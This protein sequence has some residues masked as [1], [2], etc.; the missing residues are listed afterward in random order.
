MDDSSSPNTKIKIN[1]YKI[2]YD[3]KAIFNIEEGSE[4]RC[5]YNTSDFDD[6]ERSFECY[7]EAL[8]CKKIFR[9]IKN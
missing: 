5:N 6:K 2:T 1:T 3:V 7:N 4:I 9:G 8:N